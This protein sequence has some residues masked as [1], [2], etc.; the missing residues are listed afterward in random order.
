MEIEEITNEEV[1]KSCFLQNTL[2][3]FNISL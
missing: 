2:L 3:I 1:C